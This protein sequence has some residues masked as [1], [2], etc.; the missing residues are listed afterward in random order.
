MSPII[1][2]TSIPIIANV[3][4]RTVGT[5]TIN[6]VI[7]ATTNPSITATKAS[8]I[9]NAIAKKRNIINPANINNI[10]KGIDSSISGANSNA[11]K[12]NSGNKSIRRGKPKRNTITNKNSAPITMNGKNI[13]NPMLKTK[14][15]KNKAVPTTYPIARKT[16]KNN[17]NIDTPPLNIIADT[18]E[19]ASMGMDK[20]NVKN[21]IS[22]R[23]IMRN[24]GPNIAINDKPAL[25]IS[26]ATI[27]M[28][29]I[30]IDRK[31]A[32]KPNTTQNMPKNIVRK[33]M[34]AIIDP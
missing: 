34:D 3:K 28:P 7:I 16:G 23:N 19:K 1:A 9:I 30:G 20:K 11:P 5:K 25:S 4:K 29:N 10:I 21:A 26:D 22:I 13:T 8:T 18:I 15:N 6:T 27:D 32:I 33:I 14:K 17:T 12:N 2:A 24:I 31:N